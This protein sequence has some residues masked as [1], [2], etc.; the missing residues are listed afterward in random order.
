MV[1]VT[2]GERCPGGGE[3]SDNSDVLPEGLPRS[4]RLISKVRVVQS[5]V[6]TLRLEIVDLSCEV[7]THSETSVR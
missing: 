4:S 3:P 2:L 7:E 6:R 5:S 1:G